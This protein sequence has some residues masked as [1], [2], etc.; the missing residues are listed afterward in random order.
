MQA[1][2]ETARKDGRIDI[3]IKR[4]T[5][6][7]SLDGEPIQSQDIVGFVIKDNGA[8][9]SE[10]NFEAFLTSD[11]TNKATKGGKG[12]GRFLWLKAFDR[13]KIDSMYQG[14]DDKQYRRY[15]EFALSEAGVEE[16]TIDV[17]E[18]GVYETTVT[19]DG[20]KTDYRKHCWKSIDSIGLRIIEHCL[21]SFVLDACPK[22]MLHDEYEKTIIDLQRKF[23]KEM[24]L[25]SKRQNFQ[26]KGHQFRIT[27]V[28]LV[29]GR[30]QNHLVSFCANDRSVREDDLK[31]LVPNLENV[32]TDKTEE[33]PRQFIY[34]GYI[35]G[36]FLDE[37]VVPERT[38]FDMM[39]EEPD[40]DF[41]DELTWLELLKDVAQK[42]QDYLAPFTKPLGEAKRDWIRQYVENIAP[43]YRPL[44]KHKADSLN[45]IPAN[46]TND[47]LDLELYKVDQEY[48]A[49]LRVRYQK[50]LTEGDKGTQQHEEHKQKFEQFLEEWNEA[51]MSKLARHVAFRKATL[52]FLDERLGLQENGKYSLEES[53]HEVIFPLRSTSEDVR[54]DQMNLWILD[55]KLA[56]HSYLASDKQFSQMQDAVEIDSNDRPDIAIFNR[57]F[58]FTETESPI[59]SVV[60]VEFKRP[61]RDDYSEKDGKNPI[62]QVFDYVKLI[63]SGKAK[64]RRGRP[65]NIPDSIPF[66]AYIVC[67]I[68]PTLTKQADYASLTPTPDSRGFFGY[69]KMGVYIEVISFD[70]LVDDARKR[71]AILFDKLG[72]G[73]K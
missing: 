58:A 23:K 61:A 20:F 69:H 13:A 4:D 35:S 43:Q 21:E 48:D 15:F 55:E 66:Y 25:D 28:R 41:P 39:D 24:C 38:R 64:D 27:H 26:L 42:S 57:P 73:V 72:V 44:L 18:E 45:K 63:K 70:K 54:P 22:M 59:G 60:L 46:L 8:G 49:E 51:G 16:L 65:L 7:K 11:T 1:I 62:T 56:Y 36:L 2:E 52:A 17:C 32:L 67:D 6:Q 29:P 34:A 19:L 30:D 31:S 68:T 5:S 37:R 53:V 47:K 12:V 50:L 71:N 40:L 10:N 9:F 14:E 3:Y 33:Q